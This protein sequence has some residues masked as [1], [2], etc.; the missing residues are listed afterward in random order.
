MAE[1]T[2][3]AI[4]RDGTLYGVDNAGTVLTIKPGNRE[5]QIFFPDTGAML[6]LSAT[7]AG[8]VASNARRLPSARHLAL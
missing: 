5:V 6:S 2:E 4:R 7:E 8:R 1:R 3:W